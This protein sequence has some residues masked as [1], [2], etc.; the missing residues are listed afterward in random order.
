MF[1]PVLAQQNGNPQLP[2][3]PVQRFQ[4]GGGGSG[5]QL[6]GW[7]IQN[8]QLWPGGQ[9]G[10]QVHQLFLPAGE[11]VHRPVK[12]GLQTEKGGDLRRPAADLS[13]GLAQG[14]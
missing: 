4:K 13:L 9:G 12:Q 8:Q 14:F 7:L 2:V 5:I 3:Y 6:A 11:P 1:Q 10:S